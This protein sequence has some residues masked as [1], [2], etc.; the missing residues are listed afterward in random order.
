VIT[1]RATLTRFDV[2]E[3]QAQGRAFSLVAAHAEND[4]PNQIAGAVTLGFQGPAERWAGFVDEMRRDLPAP[5]RLESPASST[6]LSLAAGVRT[7]QVIGVSAH[8]GYPHRGAN[9]VPP[10]L[11]LV[12]RAIARGSVEGD[13]RGRGSF[14]LDLRLIP[15]MPL[16]EGRMGALDDLGRW[17]REHLPNARADAPL[18]RAR[19]GYAIAPDHPAVLKLERILRE[20]S[21]EPG[22]FGEYGGT[23]ASS[24]SGIRTPAGEPLPALVFGSMDRASH[25]HE[26]EESV[27]PAMIGRVSLAIERYA[28]AP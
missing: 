13:V 9:P 11:A 12:E 10:A 21:A 17:S 15:E 3:G 6:A 28:R 4:A 18:E 7:L 2:A 1:G 23:D 26:A 27:D 8:G 14:A 24:L 16:A 19:G 5:F 25:I 20:L 22:I